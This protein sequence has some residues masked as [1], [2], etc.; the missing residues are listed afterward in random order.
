MSVMLV[1][2]HVAL[3][4]YLAL[5][6]LSERRLAQQAGLAPA[7]VNHVVSGRRRTCS[8]KT[9]LAIEAVLGCPRG[10][11]FAPMPVAGTSQRPTVR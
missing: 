10:V 3:Q 6:P 5:L 1:R 9:A 7:T 8:A 11:F 4:R 2:D